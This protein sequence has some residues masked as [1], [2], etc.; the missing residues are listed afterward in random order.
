MKVYFFI[1][2]LNLYIFSY[3]YIETNEEY[4]MYFLNKIKLGKNKKEVYLIVNSLS[5]K[6]YLFTNTKR[7]YYQEIN[8]RKNNDKFIEQVEF[9]G[10]I[11]PSF[12]FNLKKDDTELYDLTVQGEF[13]LGINENKGNQLVD[14]LYK[15]SIINEKILGLE[16]NEKDDLININLEPN[17]KELNYCDLSSKKNYDK[18]DFYYES[19]ICELSHIISGSTKN[20]LLWNKAYEV[21]GEVVFD[22]RSKYIYAPKQYMKYISNIWEMDKNNCKLVRDLDTDEK[23]Y[24]CKDLSGSLNNMKSLYLIIGGYAYRLKAQDLFENDGHNSN[25]LIKF[26][27][28]EKNLWVLGI[29]F[30]RKYKYVLDY[31]NSKIGLKGEDIINFSEEYKKWVVDAKEENSELFKTPSWEKVILVIGIIVGISIIFYVWYYFYRFSKRYNQKYQIE[32]D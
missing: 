17:K 6:T 29:P 20:D 4:T 2:F 12:P 11:I 1:I 16:L 24:Y 28:D 22:T 25:C 7:E 26:I 32:Y 27:N 30:F 14:V 15:N 18:G 3:S 9:N 5:S 21:K 19:W 23:Y 10:R 8:D 31:T 13:G